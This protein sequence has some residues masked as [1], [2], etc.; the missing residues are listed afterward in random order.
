MMDYF[1]GSDPVEICWNT[2]FA[3]IGVFETAGR[4]SQSPMA[5]TSAPIGESSWEF[6]IDWNHGGMSKICFSL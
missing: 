6:L 2:V 3:S 1:F 5:A 4:N